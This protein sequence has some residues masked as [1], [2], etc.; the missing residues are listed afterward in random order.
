MHVG[1]GLVLVKNEPK[2]LLVLILTSGTLLTLEETKMMGA[3]YETKKDLKAAIGQ[4]LRYV[5]TL[6]FG[7]EYKADGTFCVVGPCAYTNRK[8]YAA[9]TM[10]NGLISKVS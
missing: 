9:V 10:V 4:S 8:W 7:Q 2:V 1:T 6:M 3:S 5:E